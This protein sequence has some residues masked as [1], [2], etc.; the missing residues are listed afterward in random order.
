MEVRKKDN[1][2]LGI[3]YGWKFPS[4][5]EPCYLK[6]MGDLPMIKI[7]IGEKVERFQFIKGE[8]MHQ[9]LFTRRFTLFLAI[10]ALL[11][12]S[13]SAQLTTGKI[14]G[15][16][17]DK[18]TGQPVSGVQVQVE[19]TRLGNISNA[20]GYYFILS[21]PPGRRN[22]VFTYTGYQKTTVSNQLLL[23]GQTATVDCEISSTVV[24]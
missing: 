12:T 22:V 1:Y 11:A 13:L 24:Q 21:V 20:D 19:G 4:T 16:V 3:N 18:D 9:K 2:P 8:L 14:E 7:S 5:L 6:Q 17:R 23:A 15:T 10:S